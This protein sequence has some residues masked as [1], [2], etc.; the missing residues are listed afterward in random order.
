MT[1]KAKSGGGITASN[2]VNN[3][4]RNNV[5]RFINS[6]AGWVAAQEREKR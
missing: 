2:V 6:P 4:I 5:N 1:L 3:Y